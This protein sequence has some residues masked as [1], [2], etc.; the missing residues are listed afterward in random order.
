[1]NAIPDPVLKW[2]EEVNLLSFLLWVTAGVTLL[3]WTIRTVKNS[4]PA[5]KNLIELS[6][7]LEKLPGWMDTVDERLDKFQPVLEQVRHEVLPNDGGSM[8]DDL[9]TVSLQVEQL[10]AHQDNDYERLGALENTLTRRLERREQ[11]HSDHEPP[12]EN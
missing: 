10:Q 11:T 6:E 4:I 1:M 9:Q 3:V 7:S 12:K 8:R 5:L 2:L